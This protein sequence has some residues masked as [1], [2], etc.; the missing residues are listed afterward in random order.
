M[1][2]KEQLAAKK[3]AI[4]AIKPDAKGDYTEAQARQAETLLGEIIELEAK[5]AQA[6]R[7]AAI[8]G[9]IQGTAKHQPD[10]PGQYEGH[11]KADEA[12]AARKGYHWATKSLAAVQASASGM[13]LKSLFAGALAV[14]DP[15]LT[16]YS[17][18]PE[19]P[20]TLLDLIPVVGQR[21]GSRVNFLRMVAKD[22]NAAPVAMGALKPTSTYTFDDV[23]LPFEVIAHLSE[24]LNNVWASDY[25]RLIQIVGAEMANGVRRA[26]ENQIVNGT[27]TSPDLLGIL[28]TTGVTQVLFAT[29]A[30]TTV[31]KAY[32][33][34]TA[35][36]EQPTGWAVNPNDL[37]AFELLREG[38]ATGAFLM[39]DSAA[40]RVFKVPTVP[41]FAVPQGQAL[42]ADWRA[43]QLTV[44]EGVSTLAFH[45]HADLAAKNQF[46]IRSEGRYEFHIE[47]PQAVA[48]VDLTAGP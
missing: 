37:E 34:L 27:G 26:L 1:T 28:A 42:L 38:G 14:D 3:A 36:G 19:L 7:A 4:H 39:T 12:M 30:L 22:D 2:I 10:V 6:D 46:I 31:R 32:T 47:R 13:G 15:I 16:E 8:M 11:T 41:S 40:Q 24:P 5:A 48:V 21:E 17:T 25:P 44:R 43:T 45:Q 29:D 20:T 33:A 35:K 23:E 9:A 18:I